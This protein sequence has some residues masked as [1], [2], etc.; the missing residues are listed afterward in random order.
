MNKSSILL[1]VGSALL[2][3]FL[4]FWQSMN[5]SRILLTVGSACYCWQSMNKS[6]I[7]L[8]VRSACYCWQ[9]M[10]KSRILL[11]VGSARYCWQSMNKSRILLTVGS[12]CYCWQSMNKSSILLT[13]GS[14]LVTADRAWINPVCCS[15]SDLLWLHLVIRMW[16]SSMDE[17]LVGQLHTSKT[18]CAGKMIGLPTGVNKRWS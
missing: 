17:C 6:R 14:A 5:K 13:V 11:T 15:L 16:F 12:A 9:S 2:T 3:A 4:L 8:T 10:N 7:L 1:P 18:N